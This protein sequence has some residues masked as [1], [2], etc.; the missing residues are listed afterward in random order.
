M[1][2]LAMMLDGHVHISL[3]EDPS[4]ERLQG[5]MGE[6]GVKGGLLISLPPEGHEPNQAS[7]SPRARLMNVLGWCTGHETLFPFFWLDPLAE[8]ALEQV[9]M[10]V[11]LGISGFKVICDRFFPHDQQAMTV[12]RAIARQNRPILFHSGILWDGKPS[13][14]FN[15]PAEFEALGGVDDLRFALAHLGWPWCDECIAVYGKL[16]AARR[17]F[18]NS[19]VEMYVDIT[20]GTPPTYRAEALRRL[21][22]TGY[23][24]NRNVIFGSDSRTGEYASSW[25]RGLASRDRVTLEEIGATPE[26]IE[27][28]FGKGLLRFIHGPGATA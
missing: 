21:F 23:D 10:A 22:L 1:R 7:I 15:R 2:G 27:H 18:P 28:V 17:H 8:D 12:F 16:L 13:S 14:R 20:P 5:E 3:L 9:E 24:V 6:A 26:A 25:V 4:P 19:G 11:D